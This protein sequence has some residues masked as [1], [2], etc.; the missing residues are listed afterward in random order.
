MKD[1]RIGFGITGSHCT[2]EKIIG[3]MQKLI[4]DGNEVWPIVSPS[5]RDCDTRFGTARHWLEQIESICQRPVIENIV[6]AEPV[7]PKLNLDIMVLAPCTGNTIAKLALGITDTAVTMAAKAQLRNRRPVLLAIATND[8]LAANAKN[9]GLLMDKKH[10]Y[11]V[12]FG[13]DDPVGKP[14]SVVAHFDL[15]L[16]AM[17]AAL[18]EQQIQ[19]LLR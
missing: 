5:V 3:P 6:T 17:E 10:V 2:L 13:Q 12:P 9:I 8:G 1:K 18:A 7:G 15:L 19:P 16:K 11:F 14:T 4:D